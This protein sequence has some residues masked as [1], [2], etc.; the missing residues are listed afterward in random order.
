MLLSSL[1]LGWIYWI[2]EANHVGAGKASQ[3]PLAH[4]RWKMTRVHLGM[5]FMAILFSLGDSYGTI[6]FWYDEGF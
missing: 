5:L 1:I 4:T 6:D 2:V 3:T